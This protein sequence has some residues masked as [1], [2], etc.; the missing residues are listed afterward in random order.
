MHED[1]DSM[2]GWPDDEALRQ[3]AALLDVPL[4]DEQLGSVRAHLEAALTMARLVYA[5][6]LADEALVPA[7][8]FL[9]GAADTP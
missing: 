2:T 6:P 4:P 5:V 7:T 1:A 8:T 9:P 3:L